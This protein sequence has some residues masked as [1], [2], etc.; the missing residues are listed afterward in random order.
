MA[1]QDTSC[2]YST[3]KNTSGGRM[4]FGFLPPHGREL[5]NNEE[6]TIFGDV[7]E[8]IIS[9]DRLASRRSIL[10]FEA[11]IERGDLQIMQTPSIILRDTVTHNPKMFKLTSG[12]L[13][14]VDPCWFNSVG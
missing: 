12:T 1:V 5:A 9:G 4:K 7:R 2:L 3:I 11:A 10:A 13:T 6:F 8:A 14:Q